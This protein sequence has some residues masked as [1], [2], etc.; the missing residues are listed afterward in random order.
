MSWLFQPRL[1]NGPF[2]DPGLYIDF[3]YGHRAILFDL[4][5]INALSAREIMRIS[6]VFVSHT[7]VDH[8]SG[9]DRLLRVCLHKPG[10]VHLVGPPGFIDRVE[11]R[12]QGFTWNL[13]DET[14]VDFQ[15]HVGEFHEPYM[16]RKAVFAAR[17]VFMREPVEGPVLPEGIVHEEC[18]FRVEAVALDH[19]IPSLAFGLRETIRVNVRRGML[20]SMGLPTGPWLNTAKSLIRAGQDDAEI[21]IPGIGIVALKEIAERLFFV[22]P[23]QSIVYVTDTGIS[24]ENAQKITFLARDADQLFIESVF[25]DRD[26]KL[27]EAALHLTA[28]EAGRLAR[29]AN[30]K[31]MN[32]FHFS[33]RYITE[34]DALPR[35]A[36]GAYGHSPRPLPL[37]GDRNA[38]PGKTAPSGDAVRS[39][40]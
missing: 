36:F 1:V 4:G 34:P 28:G 35:E 3:R 23:G 11:H 37:N 16:A 29:A 19:G 12:L 38:R 18:D 13:I 26:R 31:R 6:H 15:L 7:H 20:E 25:L 14:S 24:P 2:D 32:V 10:P 30:V 21:E 33:G 9:F 39:R 40:P 22:G 17:R 5:E 8:F 27:A